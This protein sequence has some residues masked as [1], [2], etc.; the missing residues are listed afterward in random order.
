[1]NLD[2]YELH[3][4]PLKYPLLIIKGN[5]GFLSCAYINTD[6]CNNTKEAQAVVMGVKNHQD[7]LSAK[8]I[9]VSDSAS[10]LGVKVGMSGKQ[11]LN[12]FL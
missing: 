7:M 5:N 1:M 12:Y 3:H 2:A 10:K 4:V 9:E 6:I 8:V 11:A